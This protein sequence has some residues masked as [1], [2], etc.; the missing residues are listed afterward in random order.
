MNVESADSPFHG[1]FTLFWLGTA[2]Y[3]IKIAAE[4]WRQHGNILATN[5]IMGLVC[6]VQK[7]ICGK[8]DI[9][10]DVS[11]RCNGSRYL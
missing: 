10:Q 11:P 6:C 7:C 1:F 8:A 2:I 3:M 5:E 4:N 9:T